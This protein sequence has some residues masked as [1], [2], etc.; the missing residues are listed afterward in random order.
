MVHCPQHPLFDLVFVHGLGGSSHGTWSYER[1]PRNFWPSWLADD[2]GLS[3]CR[4]F[5]FG[6]NAEFVSHFS[7]AGILDFAKD[8]L[9]RMK[10]FSENSSG[11]GPTI[12]H[13]PIALIA[14]SLGGLIV[15]KAYII[16]KSDTQ[17]SDLIAQIRALVFLATPHKGSQYADMLNN[18]LKALPNNSAKQYVADIAHGSSALQEI[19]EQFR[20]VCSSLQLISFYE[21]Q[22]TSLRAGLKRLLLDRESSILGYPGEQSSSLVADHHGMSKYK[23]RTDSNY[24]DVRN[25]LRYVIRD[26]VLQPKDLEHSSQERTPSIAITATADTNPSSDTSIRQHLLDV[27]GI[28]DNFEDEYEFFYE[29]LMPGTCQ[30]LINQKQFRDWADRCS[31]ASPFLWLTAGPGSGKSTMASFAISWLKKNRNKGSCQHHFF[32]ESDRQKRTLS[33]CLRSIAH[34]VALINTEFRTRLLNLCDN[35][36][37]KIAQLLPSII[38]EKVFEGIMFPLFFEAPMFWVFDGL[39]EAESHADLFRLLRKTRPSN[40]VSILFFSRFDNNISLDMNSYLSSR[41]HQHFTEDD[42][43]GDIS[44]YAQNSISHILASPL[45]E[46][47]VDKIMEK[48]A[49]SFLWVKLAVEKIKRDWHTY[50]GIMQALAEIPEGVEA[51]YKRMI[52][53]IAYKKPELR[54]LA[55]RILTWAVCN[56]RPLHIDELEIALSPEYTGFTNLAQTAGEVCAQFAVVSKGKITLLHETARIFLLQKTSSLDININGTSG[57]EHAAKICINYLSDNIKWR[58]VF[59]S[60]QSLQS[61]QSSKLG[62]KS[63]AAFD[64]HPFLL[65]ALQY[66][67][68]HVSLASVDSD[69]LIERVLEF[70][71]THV[72]LWLNGVAITG[73]L[74][75]LNETAENLKTL[76]KRRA[77]SER[78]RL[79]ATYKNARD[80]QL[81]QWAQDIFR[82]LGRFGNNLRE[83]PSCAFKYLIP[84]CPEESIIYRSFAHVKSSNFTVVAKVKIWDDCLARLRV[85]ADEMASKLLRG[86]KFLVALAATSGTLV[87]WQA[88][89]FEELR[90]IHHAEYVGCIA[91]SNIS[92]LVASAGYMTVRLWNINTGEELIQMP[93]ITDAKVLAMAFGANDTEILF[94]YDDCII[95]CVNTGTGQEK[96]T[97][98]VKEAASDYTCPRNMAFSP[99]LRYI[100]IVYRGRPVAVWELCSSEIPKRCVCSENGHS[101]EGGSWNASEKVI[102]HPDNEHVLILYEDTKIVFWNVVYD[103]QEQHDHTGARALN[104]SSDGNSLLT[105]DS[106]GY[107][108]VWSLP[109]FRLIYQ[110][111]ND[112]LVSDLAFGMDN[113]RFYDLRGEFCNVWETDSLIKVNEIT[114]DD[115]SSTEDTLLSEPTITLDYSSRENVTAVCC[116]SLDQYYCSGFDDGTV[117]I[118]N[119][120]DGKKARN[121]VVT[122]D[123]T[124]SVIRLSW[125]ASEDY[126][127]S[128]DDSSRVIV[129]RLRRPTNHK[130]KWT[131]FPVCDFSTYDAV[132]QLLFSVDGNFLLVA[133][134]QTVVVMD[135]TNK[136][137]LYRRQMPPMNGSFWV[138][139]QLNPDSIIRICGAHEER[140][141]WPNTSTQN[142]APS[143]SP[144]STQQ[145]FPLNTASNNHSDLI[146]NKAFPIHRSTWILELLGSSTHYR[147]V[148]T[149]DLGDPAK[150]TPSV[151]TRHQIEGLAEYVS[152]VIGCFQDRIVFLDYDYWVCTW[153]LTL[154]HKKP[155]RHFFL[156]KHLVSSSSLALLSMNRQGTV[157]CPVGK[158]VIIV[159]GG[160]KI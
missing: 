116:D 63:L 56:F 118:F 12:G 37:S 107:L 72:L 148:E 60:I 36:G 23:N 80:D 92:S 15:K 8:L 105:S 125:S 16:G 5:T 73:N 120:A 44:E 65:Y 87:I 117:S 124:S 141:D 121:K 104:V 99:D 14:H 38:W 139:D 95:R 45:R 143:T 11:D 22:K 86:D 68:Y 97:F 134:F 157:L 52:E 46:Q 53:A 114:E 146:V 54:N 43:Y 50:E 131:V 27:L 70:L 41:S 142:F 1:D 81:R 150:S 94:A 154:G 132:E 89:T 17:Y 135:V 32:R 123:N 18:M 137:E 31:N 74:M 152:D 33:Y 93:R 110:L 85:V 129:K 115:D 147:K 144:S 101:T 113:S 82:V 138:I 58:R 88:E 156:P 136:E 10:T 20:N 62:K 79:A 119:I 90:K 77:K 49:G 71:E 130:P 25:A 76:L 24:I 9:F 26:Y 158:N 13:L 57:H 61:T 2:S 84:F 96:W 67:S 29:G 149:L 75:I 3:S 78:K 47:T 112:E 98:K 34:Q 42:F 103:E 66:W 159:R 51:M 21:T 106:G 102:W 4:I 145:L 155:Q 40:S 39:D 160:I 109:N 122:H 55:I 59:L 35:N 128:A 133:C 126:L 30:W 48:A 28:S 7:S 64:E 83:E 127:A 100:A 140:Y 153:N 19:N 91:A 69:D 6:Y 151:T 108:S 111:K